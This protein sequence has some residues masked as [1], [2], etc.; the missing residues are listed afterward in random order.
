MKKLLSR[1][2]HISI[3]SLLMLFSIPNLLFAVSTITVTVIPD[4]SNNYAEYQ[5]VTTTT[6]GVGG[7]TLEPGTDSIYV[8][9]DST[10]GVPTSISASLISVN[11]TSLLSAPNISGQTIGI[12]TPVRI[13]GGGDTIRINISASAQIRNPSDTGPHTLWMWTTGSENQDGTPVESNS[14][15]INQSTSTV[16]AAAVTPNPSVAGESASY[17][18]GFDVGSGGLLMANVSSITIAFDTSTTVPNG[19]LSGVTVNGTS[20]NAVADSDTVVI[21]TPV[22]VDNEG[23]VQVVFAS[24]TG[25][26]NPPVD[27]TYVLSIRTSS[28]P[29]FVE[30]DSFTISRSGQLSISAISA[31][32]DTVNQTGTFSFDVR[33]GSSGVLT[34][35]TGTFTVIFEQN[36]FLPSSIS[37]ENITVSS[38]GNSDIAAAVV[39]E[40][41][42]PANDDTVTITT[43]INIAY[44]A[45]VSITFNASAGYQNPSVNGN[46]ILKLYTSAETT[47]VNS[48]PFSV[49]A[50]TTTVSQ[51][52]V[53]PA[54]S[55]ASAASTYTVDFNLGNLGRLKAGSSTVTVT[56]PSGYSVNDT[57]AN[58]DSTYVTIAGGS[59]IKIDE[60]T[61]IAVNVTNR[62][63]QITL[64]DSAITQN[65]NNIVLLIGG[66]TGNTT[67]TNPS[68]EGTYQLDVRTSVETS[69]VKSASFSIGG[70]AITLNSITR[71]DS[72]VNSASSYTFNI[73][74]ETQL[75]SAENDYVR[76]V[77][78]AGTVLPTTIATTDMS[79]NTTAPSSI[80]VD[81]GTRS[82]TARVSQN[83]NTNS[84]PIDVFI[85]STAN[86]INPAV[87]SATF[88]RYTL[89][90]S[91]DT[92]LVTSDPYE[93]I[94]D[95]TQATA[96]SASA[97]PSVVG[98]DSVA[99]TV[100]FTTS[101]TGKLVGGSAAG[102]S[103]ITVD[104]DV[105]TN[106]PATITASNVEI[107]STP[108]E[109][110]NVDASGVGGTVTITLPNGIS[111]GNSSNVSVLFKDVLGFANEVV[112]TTITY[113]VEVTTSADT[114]VATGNYTLT[115]TQN[116]S[117]TSVTPNPTTQNAN[118]SYS[119]R[120]TTGSNTL[121]ASGD[122]I[123]M[124]FPDNTGFPVSMKATDVTVNG[125]TLVLDPTIEGDTLTVRTPIIIGELTE[126]TVLIN[127]AA[128]ILNPTLAQGY[129]LD[130][131]TSAES[132]PFT[133]PNYNITQTSSTVSAA[134]V[135]PDPV[136]PG[137][138]VRAKYTI[139]FNVGSSGR[140]LAG[141]STITVTFN[142]STTVSTT[143][144]E[145]DST[146]LIVD[147]IRT[148]VTSISVSDRAV[149]LTV[150]T[151]VSI[152]N[153]EAVSVVFDSTTTTTPIGNPTTSG[154]YTLQ[155]R[156]SVETSNITSNTYT[157]TNAS[158]VTNISAELGVNTV[159]AESAYTISF[160][161]QSAVNT[162][163]GTITITFPSNTLIPSSITTSTVSIAN[164]PTTPATF[165]NVS[166]VST[167]PSTRTVTITV[168]TSIDGADSVRVRFLSSSGIENPSIDTD[169]TLNVRTSSQNVNGTSSA[170]TLSATTTH[171]QNLSV[172]I[173]PLTPSVNGQFEFSFNTNIYGRLVSGVS[174]IFL[175]FPDDV[176]LPGTT[177]S[178]T[179]V[180]VNGTAADALELRPRGVATTD[181]DTLVIT[182]PSSVTIGNMTNVDVM[183]DSTAGIQNA[184][185]TAS[186]TY[187]AYT[188]V[189]LEASDDFS[190]PVEL[191]SFAVESSEGAVY[192]SWT[193][194]SELE[195]AY[196][197][198]QRATL[199]EAEYEDIQQGD[200]KFEDLGSQFDIIAHVDGKGSIAIETN[201]T[202][203]DSL[204]E[205][206]MVY[207]YRLADVSY[208]G[209]ITIHEIVYQKV[210]APFIFKLYKNYPNPFNPS[211]TIKYSLPID[212]QVELKV[213]NILGQEVIT[214]VDDVNKAGFHDIQWHGKNQVGNSVA[215]GM[216]FV[217][218]NAKGMGSGKHFNQVMKVIFLK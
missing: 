97:S 5:I 112:D 118:A 21:T 9:F 150:P 75:R 208:S 43:P 12:P 146:F 103:A 16:T 161:V 58:Y 111:I 122:S 183:I 65:N 23:S 70:K 32:P 204:V 180:R 79:I 206:N 11:G 188:S 174:Q 33:T 18:I 68:T 119:V 203:I 124:V 98:V 31:K 129:T 36:T 57:L 4:T 184:S 194:E 56:F 90:T 192:L 141:T 100:N 128:G 55:D 185:T 46:Y 51:A 53:T 60:S 140:L 99:Y 143:T 30:S 158:A 7:N 96:V 102:S 173:I 88:Y 19:A 205:A 40:K 159:N 110:V 37:A 26:M 144:A 134:T 82:V 189:E 109:T 125:S 145:Y 215:S 193:T 87:P 190:L 72:T 8:Q 81:T 196:W 209:V 155:V 214:L 170:Y 151:G 178:T 24:G 157:I 210:D 20:A 176:T 138:G 197:M 77:F 211:T 216:Y 123:R 195:N 133:S 91:K 35:N 198:I 61:A 1:G 73:D 179:R 175:L 108:C 202:Y 127:Q 121:L 78:P 116:L 59:P 44:S 147:G 15:T 160:R 42:N 132:G 3:I 169:Y 136:S 27:S 17:T 93:M 52:L 105:A 86:I 113:T 89:N 101:S 92:K 172:N 84:N 131:I 74:I 10:T 14:Y 39:V 80:D 106:V 154:E 207:A 114:T 165:N 120:F 71:S 201:Y 117:V 164:D 200:V 62:T 34:A 25:L 45:D 153:N 217:Y 149:T 199:T 135:T 115:E 76:I 6:G 28:E 167:N 152:T 67:I 107:N 69:N 137:P 41:S 95:A 212:A 49:F 94:G 104:F 168:L 130:V 2:K 22:D 139:N 181:P 163:S 177:P 13:E 182:V 64:P 186:L 142:S 148:R 162:P 83:V 85:D 191:T 63:V 47:P 218:F 187:Q 50:T 171:I 38:D 66:T 54:S 48:N 166:S 213:F 29:T 156:T 126:V